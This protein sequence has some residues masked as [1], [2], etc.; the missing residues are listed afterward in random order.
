MSKTKVFVLE[1]CHKIGSSEIAFYVLYIS[2]NR[3]YLK[4]KRENKVFV[5]PCMQ[6]LQQQLIEQTVHELP[7]FAECRERLI[8]KYKER[9]AEVD[10]VSK[11]LI[12][13]RHCLISSPSLIGPWLMRK[14]AIFIERHPLPM[15]RPAPNLATELERQ[16]CQEEGGDLP[17]P[18]VITEVYNRKQALLEI[19]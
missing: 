10:L 11:D 6:F 18:E 14:K 8:G 9:L 1:C 7:R 4:V 3:G 15:H 17:C 16:R 19:F 5:S 2:Q 12:H 13:L